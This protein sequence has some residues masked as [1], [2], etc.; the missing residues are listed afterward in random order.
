STLCAQQYTISTFA[1]GGVPPSSVPA[2]SISLPITGGVA[3]DNAG[4]AYFISGNS[5]VKV[6]ANGI[7]TP[8][9]GTGKLGYAGDGGS[10]LAA[11]LA[12]PVS[13]ALDSS[14]NIYVADSANHRIRRIAQDGIITTVAGSGGAGS[15]GD[16]G[17]ATSAQLNSPSSV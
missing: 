12:W 17:L 9:A 5:V 16:G 8:C 14:G 10:A 13:V 15:S 2:T 11:Q 1:G 3:T 6:D 7:L 4:S